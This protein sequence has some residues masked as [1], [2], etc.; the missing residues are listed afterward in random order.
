MLEYKDQ[1]TT[2]FSELKQALTKIWTVN[3][4]FRKKTRMIETLL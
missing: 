3:K 1:Y 2:Q 4:G